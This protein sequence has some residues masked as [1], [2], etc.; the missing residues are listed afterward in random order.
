MHELVEIRAVKLPT[1]G[2]NF[3][4]ET[5]SLL[6]GI[7]LTDTEMHLRASE[8]SEMLLEARTVTQDDLESPSS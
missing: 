4:N 2:E 3:R 5:L 6:S 8:K 1:E 7:P